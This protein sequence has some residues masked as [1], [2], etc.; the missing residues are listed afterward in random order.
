[1]QPRPKLL[2][3]GRNG[4]EA[5]EEEPGSKL[6]RQTCAMKEVLYQLSKPQEKDTINIHPLGTLHGQA[7]EKCI[8]IVG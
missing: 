5:E 6:I 1:M 8:L 4:A 2:L 3:G 7:A